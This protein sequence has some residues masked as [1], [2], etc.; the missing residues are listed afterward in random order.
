M[1]MYSVGVR[2]YLNKCPGN[3]PVFVQLPFLNIGFGCLCV[4]H[5]LPFPQPA[6]EPRLYA[7]YSGS[8]VEGCDEACARQLCESYGTTLPRVYDD[9][10][11]QNLIDVL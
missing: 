5:C 3:D 11:F 9:T 2:V 6:E 8:H 1:V 4:H 7:V 10:D